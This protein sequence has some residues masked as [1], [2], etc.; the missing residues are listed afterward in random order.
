MNGVE[1]YGDFNFLKGGI[2]CAD[3]ITTV[4]PTYSREILTE[5][6]GCGLEGVLRARQHKLHG[7][8]NGADYSIWNPGNNKFI[9]C[10]Y[11][12]NALKGKRN[13]K[14]SLINELHL[15]PALK[16]KPILGFIGRLRRQKG[17][18][19]LIDILPQLLQ[20]DV[21]VVVLGEGNLEKEARLQNMMEDYPGRLSTLVSYTEDLA[22]R[23]Q[24]GCDIFLM[25][26][27][28]EPCGLTQMYALRFGTPPVA[29][30]V[31]GLRD[32]IVPWPDKDATGFIFKEP[33]SKAFLDAVMQA[34]TV[35]KTTPDAWQAMVRRA[36]HQEFTWER[37]AAEYIELY[38]EL[39]MQ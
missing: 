35:W 11:G 29:T 10:N 28:Y 31:G 12:V 34:V 30:A 7:I 14:I 2:S 4:S 19:L 23:I 13:C 27:T 9:P 17:V 15:D 6:F 16:D 38:R 20:Q 8:L 37:S 32:T 5:E 18:D 33:T 36:M 26:S 3:K 1:F 25:P 22:H 21:G 24:A 39:G